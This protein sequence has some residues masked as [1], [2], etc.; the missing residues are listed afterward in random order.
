MMRAD[1]RVEKHVGP[2][3]QHTERIGINGL[4]QHTRQRVIGDAEDQW[5]KPHSD[6]VMH[7]IALHD[8]IAQTTLVERQVGNR[9]QDCQ[10]AEGAKHEPVRNVDFTHGPG[11]N[12][13][14]EIVAVQYDAT[15]K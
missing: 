4:A 12:R 7:V 2:K 13:A 9:V 5:C 8:D 15:A 1:K 3:A 10:P 14:V 11:R 6:T